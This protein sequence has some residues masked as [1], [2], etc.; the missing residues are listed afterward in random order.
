MQLK[1]FANTHTHKLRLLSACWN[2][3]H[4]NKKFC[5]SSLLYKKQKKFKIQVEILQNK[6][7]EKNAAEWFTFP[8]TN[9]QVNTRG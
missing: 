2:W 8:E 1:Y 3:K 7:P 5:F 9:K 4:S 6:K